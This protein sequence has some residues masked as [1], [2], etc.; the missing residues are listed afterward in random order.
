MKNKL[1]LII[2]LS[3]FT[4]GLF[5]KQ[6]LLIFSKTVGWHHTSIPAGITAIIKLGQEN[7]F[8]V[9]TTIDARKFTYANLKQYAAVIFL[10]T[11]GDVLDIAQQAEFEKYIKAGGGFVGVHSATDTEYDWPWYGNLVGAYFKSH[12]AQQT[13]VFHVV[14]RDFIATKHLPAEWKRFDELYNFKWISPDIHVLITIDE[15]TYTGGTNGDN[16]P[17][18]WYHDYDGGRS[19]YTA[20]GHTD[21]SYVDPLYLKHLL[22]GIEYAM[23]NAGK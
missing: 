2:L 14:D 6:R 13:A 21:E 18:S 23:G 11:T 3:L 20:L 7:N 9:D 16:H 8:D 10:N 5:A 12:P 4:S 22:G 17:M 15:K 1:L 19:F